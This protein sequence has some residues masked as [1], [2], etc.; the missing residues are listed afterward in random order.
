MPSDF[1]KTWLQ[2]LYRPCLYLLFRVEHKWDEIVL[3]Y[4]KNNDGERKVPLLRKKTFNSLFSLHLSTLILIQ[5][6]L[7]M[8]MISVFLC[9]SSFAHFLCRGNLSI[10]L[11]MFIIRFSMFVQDRTF[12][13]ISSYRRLP[14]WWPIRMDSSRCDIGI[15]DHPYSKDSY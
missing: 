10:I 12:L 1:F 4:N 3:K 13:R 15:R 2:P 11:C 8:F 6:L 7:C 14:H 5:Y 9:L